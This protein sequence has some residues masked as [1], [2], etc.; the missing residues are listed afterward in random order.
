MQVRAARLAGVI[1]SILT[2]NVLGAAYLPCRNFD[3]TIVS[4]SVGPTAYRGDSRLECLNEDGGAL[5]GLFTG[6]AWIV[7]ETTGMTVSEDSCPKCVQS[8]WV[9]ATGGAIAN[10][11][12]YRSR[13]SG[14]STWTSRM[15]PSD[16]QCAAGGGDDRDEEWADQ[17][18]SSCQSPLVLDLNGDGIWTTSIAYPVQFDLDADGSA[19]TLAW[20]HPA[21]EEGF[22]WRDLEPNG[23][24]D[25]GGELFGVGTLLPDGRRAADGFEALAVYDAASH[26][27]N[28]DNRITARDAI[29]SKLR[30]WIDRNHDGVS[31]QTEIAPIHRF[32]VTALE[33]TYVVRSG[34]DANG[35]QHR[36]AG[37]YVHRDG[38]T[39]AVL[40]MTDVFFVRR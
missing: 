18:D 21:T 34:A 29:W 5:E 2:A 22:L 17:C 11:H 6:R 40:E 25:D 33:L 39:D 28:S 15:V 26:G 16:Q 4:F 27:G 13:I 19:E 35:N 36:L 30:V 1:L 14:V 7:D 3:L 32:G 10:G 8:V 38:S 12:C 23:V 20:T 24:V 9:G 31:Q 37:T